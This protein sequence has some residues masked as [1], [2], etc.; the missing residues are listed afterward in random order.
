MEEITFENLFLTNVEILEQKFSAVFDPFSGEVISVG[1]SF[2]FKDDEHAIEI[3]QETALMIIE[4]KILLNSC[5]VDLESDKLEFIQ[6]KTM[7]KID[8]LLHRIPDRK[9]STFNKID[10][11]IVYY[12]KTKTLKFQL[13]EEFSGTKKLPKKFQPVQARK[14]KWDGSTEMNFLITDYNDPNVVYST[15]SF[16]IDELIG[17]NKTI[18]NVEITKNNSIYTRRIFKNCVME[19]K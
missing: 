19:V 9:W 16:S 8:D 15:I 6:S 7:F 2:A 12:G 13:S 18:H 5:F 14:I 4:G 17:K 11:Y 10:L 3:D 1:P